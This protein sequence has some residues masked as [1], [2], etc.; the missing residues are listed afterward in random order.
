MA[1]WAEQQA[2]TEMLL[3]S[4]GGVV[5]FLP[6]LPSA[7]PKGSFRGLRARGSIEVDC[8]WA[9]GKATIA[10]LRA[11]ADSRIAL[12]A[13]A[14][15]RILRVTRLGKEFPLQ[16]ANAQTTQVELRAGSRYRITFA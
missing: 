16:S 7:W 10:T 8:A 13:P 9:N 11:N 12:A 5:R 1:I 6:A 3:Q 2:S 15:Q 4:H 14:G